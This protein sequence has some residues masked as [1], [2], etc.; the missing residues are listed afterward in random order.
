MLRDL[1]QE[2]ARSQS[3]SLSEYQTR[4]RSR[5]GSFGRPQTPFVEW[6]NHTKRRKTGHLRDYYSTEE[7]S[8]ATKMSLRLSG[9]ASAAKVVSDITSTYPTRAHKCITA[10]K[11]VSELEIAT[12]TDTVLVLVLDA[13]LTIRIYHHTKDYKIVQQTVFSSYKTV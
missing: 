5:S 9:A 13:K 10:M 3:S 11:K 4:G 2:R 8:Y 1:Q 7:L 6:N 12:T